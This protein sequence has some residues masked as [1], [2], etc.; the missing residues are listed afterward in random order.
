MKTKIFFWKP[1]QLSL[2]CRFLPLVY[3]CIPPMGISFM[4]FYLL[5]K[6][7]FMGI[8]LSSFCGYVV[9]GMPMLSIIL[10]LIADIGCGWWGAMLCQNTFSVDLRIFL[11]LREVITFVK[12]NLSRPLIYTTPKIVAISLFSKIRSLNASIN[13]LAVS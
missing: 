13:F 4:M 10:Y 7:A 12:I 8:F 1:I 2:T 9:K 5:G 11:N 3:L 6:N